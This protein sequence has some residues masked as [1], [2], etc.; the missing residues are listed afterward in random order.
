MPLFHNRVIKTHT[1]NAPAIP[2]NHKE[3]LQKWAQNLENHIYDSETQNDG[4]FIQ[5]ILIDVLGY[6]GSSEGNS[7]NVAKNQSVGKGNV[8]VALGE[9]SA[10]S[11]NIIA[12]FELKGAKTRDLDM[13]MS[14]RHKSPVQQAW[15]YAMDAKG[16]QW[17]LVSNYREIRL[18]AIG[19]GRK[20]FETFDLSKLHE[21]SEYARFMLLLSAPNFLD[22]TTLSLLKESEKV[23]KEITDHLYADYKKLRAALIKTI[24]QDNPAIPPL[25]VIKH[26]QTILDRILF[27]AFAEDKTLLPDD[28]L[29]SAYETQNLYSPQPVW[30]NFKG[31]FHAIDKGNPALKIPKYNGGLFAHSPEL[32]N[33]QISNELCEGFKKIG[34]Y[35]FQSE[36]S[37]NILGHIF[38]QSISDLE[39]LKA[40]AEG[41]QDSLDKSKGKRKKDGIFYTPA[42]ITS[43]IVEQA[44]GGW[45]GDR[46]VEI[47]FDKLPELGDDD[48]AS[49]SF[50]ARGKRKGQ[51][52]YNKKIEKHIAAWEAYKEKLS[53][54]KVLDPACGSGAF[55]NEV[56]DY[57]K[58]EGESINSAL[59]T[60]KGGQTNAFKWDTHILANNIFGV[61]LNNESVEITKLS[62]W[63]KTA[64][65]GEKLTYLDDN[66]KIGNSLI[67]DQQV[68]GDKAFNWREQFHDIMSA[69]GFDVIVGNPPY[70][71]GLSKKDKGFIKEHYKTTE[72]NF[73]T[74]ISFFELSINLMKDFSYIGFITPN[75]FLVTENATKIRELLI[76]NNTLVS[77]LE[78]FNVF[79]DAVVEPIISIIK[80]EPPAK[81]HNVGIIT[82]PRNN[83]NV[84]NNIENANFAKFELS[85]IK[86]SALMFNYRACKNERNLV[87]KI[88]NKT[89]P[90]SDSF[91][92]TT[93]IK[94]Y[95]KGKGKPPQTSEIVKNKPFT[96]FSC[97]NIDN[98]KKLI[99]GT[100]IK[101]YNVSWA[102][103]Y[104]DY[105]IHLA[106]PRTS[107][108]FFEDKLF[109]RRTDDKLMSC[110]DGAQF[111]GINSIHTINCKNTSLRNTELTFLL[112]LLNSK[113]LN[114]IFQYNNF[115][116][117]GKPLAEVKVVF[118][119]RLP[120]AN[121]SDSEK[122]PL[123]ELAEKM[124]EL[125]KNLQACSSSFLKLLSAEFTL[126]K[127]GKKLEKWHELD[128]AAFI[129][130]LEKRTKPQK[131][132]LLQKAEWLQHFEAEKTK[133]QAL[134]LQISQTDN[135]I[136]ALV[137]ALYDLTP[138]EIKLV[139]G[140]E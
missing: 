36:V 69:G 93:G 33:L 92:V 25:D 59:T 133:A 113:L 67:D 95:Q 15:E 96:S 38:E 81:N 105:G 106:E 79:P 19:Y 85:E 112:S 73:D 116:M 82:I 32:E 122:Q 41:S 134:T 66:I 71:A 103:E 65:R 111:V 87:L 37:V 131:I 84:E 60:L 68:A 110:F 102:G 5:R 83:S 53:Q 6:I 54:I 43:Y 21:Q 46:K 74:Y 10:D 42:Y 78:I 11:V 98:W 137:Y 97:P 9:F 89:K 12:P 90:L 18:Y 28:T 80:K 16:A 99:R 20:D 129:S 119:E 108:Y 62:L 123:I 8:D 94:P 35:D 26:S 14:G 126:E 47:G 114:Y 120:I 34:D 45:L 107:K 124:L 125:N 22:G 135:E 77:L 88:Q 24:G 51:I 58:K 17:V 2:K 118:V 49:I 70:G 50:V 1:K 30:D 40:H 115:H 39:E 63:L 130:E 75:T 56:F 109:I 104:I 139:E 29:K 117:V 55:L 61:D 136:D 57:L 132:T 3:A 13:V 86:E 7:W 64:N 23:D 52:T 27:I 138:D 4:E 44:V 48:Y 100:D 140:K 91:I 121:A 127:L 31:L 72:Y 128:F 101:R 76:L